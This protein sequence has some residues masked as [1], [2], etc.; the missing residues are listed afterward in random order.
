[1]REPGGV[2]WSLYL[3][4]DTASVRAVFTVDKLPPIAALEEGGREGG[5]MMVVE[6]WVCVAGRAEGWGEGRREKEGTGRKKR[7]REEVSHCLEVSAWR[8]GRGKGGEEGREGQEEGGRAASIALEREGE[9][10]RKEKKRWLVVEELGVCGGWEGRGCLWKDD[11]SR[12]FVGRAQ[13]REDDSA[14][15]GCLWTRLEFLS[16]SPSTSPFHAPYL[17]PCNAQHRHRSLA[18]LA[19]T[20]RLR[21]Q[22]QRKVLSPSL[23]PSPPPS[24]RREGREGGRKRTREG[25]R[26]GMAAY[27]CRR[28]D[29]AA[30]L[31]PGVYA[32]AKLLSGLQP[33]RMDP[34]PSEFASHCLGKL[35]CP[36]VFGGL[37]APE[38]KESLSPPTLVDLPSLSCLR[39]TI[40]VR[41]R[42]A[43]EGRE[44]R[45][46]GG[47]EG[48]REG[49]WL[50][51]RGEERGGEA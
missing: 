19:W 8:C 25:G 15:G 24:S 21:G 33:L 46:E 5:K 34:P 18:F 32:W 48:G 35:P 20:L 45:K 9:R 29:A 26:E 14:L 42:M 17:L 16:F 40:A 2:P 44:G 31:E 22:L 23:P 4:D 38:D 37:P 10:R 12:G 30:A 7:G 47:R 6:N 3:E 36:A 49:G 1:M 39:Q 28:E 51:I 13:T 50:A 27:R 11:D 41:A 43:L